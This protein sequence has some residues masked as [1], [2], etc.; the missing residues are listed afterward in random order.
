MVGRFFFDNGVFMSLKDLK[1]YQERHGEMPC[2]DGK[3]VYGNKTS[4]FERILKVIVY[5]RPRY[6][7]YKV[8]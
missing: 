1:E 7:S 4:S 6:F 2:Q 8:K 3:F 5:E